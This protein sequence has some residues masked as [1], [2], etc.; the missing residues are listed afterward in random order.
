VRAQSI[1]D[2][3]SSEIQNSCGTASEPTERGSASKPGWEMS[4][5]ISSLT[6]NTQFCR[7]PLYPGLQPLRARMVDGLAINSTTVES[8]RNKERK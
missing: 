1:M 8:P 3:T 5:T 4:F 2:R 6:L 7:R